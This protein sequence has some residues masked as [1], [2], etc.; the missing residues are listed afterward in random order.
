MKVNLWKETKNKLFIH[1]K[2]YSETNKLVI[3]NKEIHVEVKFLLSKLHKCKEDKKALT[4]TQ[5]LD[6]ITRE[7]S[8]MRDINDEN[9]YSDTVNKLASFLAELSNKIV[10]ADIT[11]E[12]SNQSSKK[13]FKVCED[14]KK[15]ANVRIRVAARQFNSNNV[16]RRIIRMSL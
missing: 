4:K 5:T 10:P 11:K 15:N 8:M 12:K 14:L 3:D 13:K 2:T 6:L 9:A 1:L 16:L 7:D